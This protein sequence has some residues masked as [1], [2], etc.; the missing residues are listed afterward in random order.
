ML[1]RANQTLAR[2]ADDVYLLVA[3]IPMQVKGADA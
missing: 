2:H 3:G 1:G